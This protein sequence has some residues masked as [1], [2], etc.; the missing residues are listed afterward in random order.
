[1]SFFDDGFSQFLEVSYVSFNYLGIFYDSFSPSFPF[2]TLVL[3]LEWYMVLFLRFLQ[4]VIY[5]LIRI[6]DKCRKMGGES[7]IFFYLLSKE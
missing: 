6:V 1:V 2:F 4:V 3:F 5:R 7:C